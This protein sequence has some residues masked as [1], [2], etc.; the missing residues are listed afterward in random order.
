MVVVVVSEQ[1][2]TRRLSEQGSGGRVIR[3]FIDRAQAEPRGSPVPAGGSG[4]GWAPQSNGGPVGR[5]A[6]QGADQVE[7]HRL[8]AFPG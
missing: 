2:V 6:P 8:Y 3:I 5:V 4:W 7:A 1:S